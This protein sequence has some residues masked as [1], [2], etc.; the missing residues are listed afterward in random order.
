[1]ALSGG[2]LKDSASTLR[3][4]SQHSAFP[5]HCSDSQELLSQ[6]ML[7]SL[8]EGKPGPGAG[9]LGQNGE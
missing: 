3:M 4:Q 6:L 5:V 1:M 9:I 8:H 2:E 7:P